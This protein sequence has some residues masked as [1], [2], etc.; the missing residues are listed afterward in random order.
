MSEQRRTTSGIEVKPV[1]G[2]GNE[3]DPAR[4][5]TPGTFPFTRGL[6][7]DGYRTR[8]WTI[9]QYAGYGTAQEANERF[10]FLLAQGQPGLS[11]AFDLPTQMGLDSDDP[12]SLGEV[13]TLG[14]AIDSLDDVVAL[15]DCIQIGRAHV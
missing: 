3:G 5:G 14:V 1:Y 9:R 15:F 11:V 2:P 12:R 4:I 13:G 6:R 8:P 7:A 10:R